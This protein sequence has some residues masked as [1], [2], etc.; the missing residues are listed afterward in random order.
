MTAVLLLAGCT[1]HGKIRRGI[2]TQPR[3][4]VRTDTTV[5]VISDAGIEP[6]TLLME[7]ATSFPHAFTLETAD[8]VAV[9]TADALATVVERV[10]AGPQALAGK[11]PYQALVTYKAQFTSFDCEEEKPLASAAT[12]GLCTRVTLTISHPNS[13]QPLFERSARRWSPVP[14]VGLA[15][16]L[17]WLNKHTFSLL[18]PFTGPIY[19][20]RRGADLRHQLEEDLQEILTEIMQHLYRNRTVFESDPQTSL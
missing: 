2:Y 17:E 1:Y 3:Q 9:A 15:G 7:P 6:H 12:A 20:Q 18:L 5:L 4:A 8:G 16:G 19:M 14:Q 13:S 11:Y 10:D